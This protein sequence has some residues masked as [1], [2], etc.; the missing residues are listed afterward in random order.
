VSFEV[1]LVRYVIH[2]TSYT[3]DDKVEN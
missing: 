3:L 2:M 1:Y